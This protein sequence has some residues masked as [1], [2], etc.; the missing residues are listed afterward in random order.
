MKKN[1]FK[2]VAGLLLASAFAVNA[3]AIALLMGSQAR[4]DFMEKT[5]LIFKVGAVV[6]AL[7]NPINLVLVVLA[8]D[9]DTIQT[10]ESQ[11]REKSPGM[12]SDEVSQYAIEAFNKKVKEQKK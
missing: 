9:N 7:S 8:E 5:P 3:N 6:V 2:P 11:I 12:S 10:L 1:Y 4:E